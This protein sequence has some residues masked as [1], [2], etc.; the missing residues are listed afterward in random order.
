MKLLSFSHFRS[1]LA[2]TVVVALQAQERTLVPGAPGNI[3][4]SPQD[5]S[6]VEFAIVRQASSEMRLIDRQQ[7]VLFV[8]SPAANA[9]EAVANL[10]L[11]DVGLT[12]IT[13]ALAPQMRMWN[14][15]M[16][17]V[18]R[19]GVNLG[20]GVLV[21][22]GTDTRGFE[23]DTLAGT[24]ADVTLREGNAEFLIPMKNYL[25]SA[26]FDISRVQPVLIRLEPRD[27]DKARVIASRQVLLK[28]NKTGRFDLKPTVAREESK[29]DQRRVD[30]DVER[31]PGNVFKLTPKEPL[32][33]GEFALV[34]RTAA[35][36]GPYTQNVALRPTPIFATSNTPAQRSGLLGAFGG[37]SSAQPKSEASASPFGML[38]RGK[39]ATG[40]SAATPAAQPGMAGF[41]AWDFRV[42]KQ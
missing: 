10:L 38:R 9:R 19:K 11:S 7:K 2:L 42:V 12:L 22:H 30:A 3:P 4:A 37:H 33:A 6:N 20:R 32:Q 1:L 25:P 34:F 36:K 24:T 28:E 18:L 15:Y 27:R 16:N 13:M 35:E 41:L 23:Y 40:P 14:P 31:L 39:T 29:V 21:G 8:K 5:P 17:D 26:D